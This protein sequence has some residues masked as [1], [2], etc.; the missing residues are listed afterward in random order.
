MAPGL[1]YMLAGRH[2]SACECITAV[3]SWLDP[4]A[5]FTTLG[6]AKV[7]LHG[8]SDVGMSKSP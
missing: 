8:W 6:M 1:G 3:T 7:D 5:A 4:V 2:A